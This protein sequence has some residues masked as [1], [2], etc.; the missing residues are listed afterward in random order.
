MTRLRNDFRMH[1]GFAAELPNALGDSVRVLLLF[2]SMLAELRRHGSRMNTRGHEVMKLV[3]QHTHELGRQRLVQ[4]ADSLLPVEPVVFGHRT[5][6]DLLARPG[7]D[8]FNVFQE[9]HSLLLYK[10]T[11]W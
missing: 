2:L 1:L 7:S 3:A 6:F 11:V 8:L 10:A 9:L 5:V 4:N